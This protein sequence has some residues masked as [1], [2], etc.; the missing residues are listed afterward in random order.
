METEIPKRQLRAAFRT[1]LSGGFVAKLGT[2]H[3]L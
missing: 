2:S 1:E 3:M